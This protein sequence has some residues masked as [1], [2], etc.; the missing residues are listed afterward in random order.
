VPAPKETIKHHFTVD[1]EEYFQVAAMEPYV[2]RADW[3]KIGARVEIGTRQLLSLL[4]AHSATG[5]FFTLGWIADKHPQLVRDIAAA[6]HEVASH[7]WGH[8]RVTTLTPDQFRISVR[9]SRKILED[10]S[11]QRVRGYRAP[12]FSII[13]GG[14]WALDILLEEGYTYDSSLFPIF[15]SGYGYRGGP[16]DPYVIRRASGELHEFPPTTLGVGKVLVPAGGGGY[17]RLLPYALAKRAF[18][19]TETRKVPGTFYIHPWELDPDQPRL[20]VSWKTRI[21]H[22]GGLQKT[23]PRLE[24]LMSDFRFQSIAETLA[25]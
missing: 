9:D 24:Q 17:F 23:I 10:V 2:D 21:R 18:R 1:V 6:G 16:Q 11:G 3:P 7:G 15:R 12:S 14:E 4:A 13:R 25:A 8:E 22:Y 20:P 5:T 19:S